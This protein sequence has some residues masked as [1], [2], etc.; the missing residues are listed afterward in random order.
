MQKTAIKELMYGGINELMQNK[1]FYY[2][3]SVGRSYSNW[4]D[5]GQQALSEFV[6][7]IA[8]MITEAEEQDLDQRA[9]QL[10]IKEL[11]G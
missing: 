9:K 5:E 7:E 4:T 2:R 6:S 11:K 1:R 8:H 10:V 3:S